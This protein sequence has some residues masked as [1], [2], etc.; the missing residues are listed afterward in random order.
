MDRM[1]LA[2]SSSTPGISNRV[3]R[4]ADFRS[5]STVTSL[6]RMLDVVL[7]MSFSLGALAC[8]MWKT[9]LV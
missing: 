2:R 8:L 3:F 6:V 9:G 7:V 1:V 4:G 5:I